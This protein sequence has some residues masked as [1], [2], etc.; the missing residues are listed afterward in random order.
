MVRPHFHTQCKDDHH[1][2]N[3]MFLA[4]AV[5]SVYESSRVEKALLLLEKLTKLDKPSRQSSV[6]SQLFSKFFIL[7]D[8]IQFEIY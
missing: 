8:Y 2:D 3:H 4:S 1:F 7:S 5:A 6:N